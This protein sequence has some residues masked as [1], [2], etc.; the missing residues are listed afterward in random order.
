MDKTM[1]KLAVVAIIVFIV[2]FTITVG[3]SLF[4]PSGNIIYKNQ[5]NK[6]QLSTCGNKICD[7]GENCNN[8][9]M[10]CS[11]VELKLTK[12]VEYSQILIW[13]SAKVRYAAVN[14]GNSPSS[15]VRLE[16]ISSAP[17]LGKIRDRKEVYLGSFP[18]NMTPIMG[19]ATVGYDCSDDIVLIITRLYDSAGNEYT[20]EIEKRR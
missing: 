16:I 5:T 13:C 9:P 7:F 14:S 20:E 8:C 6:S 4:S 2:L 18:V 17:H 19:E 12:Q 1:L 11:C 10:D 15:D 3:I